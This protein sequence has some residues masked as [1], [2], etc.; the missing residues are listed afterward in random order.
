M[1]AYG[2]NPKYDQG[3]CPGHDLYS[4]DSYKNNRSKR[5]QTKYTKIAHR[6]ERRTTKQNIR[7]EIDA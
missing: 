5:A 1:K 4:R 7:R 2:V 6:A 3:C